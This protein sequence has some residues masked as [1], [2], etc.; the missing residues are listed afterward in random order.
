MFNDEMKILHRVTTQG[1][2]VATRKRKQCTR[3]QATDSLKNQI[4]DMP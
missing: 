4:V 3:T 1:M 2:M